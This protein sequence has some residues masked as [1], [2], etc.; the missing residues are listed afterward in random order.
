MLELVFRPRVT[1]RVGWNDKHSK[2]LELVLSGEWAAE[3]FDDGRVIERLLGCANSAF[4][5][6]L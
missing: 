3:L 5:Q 6:T 1:P 2:M 4:Y